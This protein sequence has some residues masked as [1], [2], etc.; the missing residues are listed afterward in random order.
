MVNLRNILKKINIKG[1]LLFNEPMSGHTTYETGGPA[2][3][4][5][6]PADTRELIEV[7]EAA[8]RCASDYFILGGGANLLVSDK[9]IP[10]LVIDIKHFD[11]INIADDGRASFGSGLIVDSAAEAALEAGFSGFDSFYGMP[12]TVGGAVWMNAR[13]YGRS[14]SDILASV[15]YLNES[16]SI[17]TMTPQEGDFDY[18]ISPFQNGDSVILEAEFRLIKCSREIIRKEMDKNRS[19]REAKGHYAGP[20]AG[21]VFKN[22]RAF[23]KPSGAIIDSLN[24]RGTEI[25]GAK[26]SDH[27]ANIFIN[28]GNATSAD[29]YRLINFVQTK[30][31]DELGFELEP[32]IRMVGDFSDLL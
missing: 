22:N 3:I 30:V 28:K 7:L 8:N 17:R 14:I 16:H 23:G 12:G 31:R 9:G 4:F 18:K 6:V 1:E 26:I 24:L 20:S 15:T 19:D 27:H 25:G 29:I 10:G 2:E 5:C 21:S 11:G 13:C 32:E